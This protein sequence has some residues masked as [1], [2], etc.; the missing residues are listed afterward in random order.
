MTIKIINYN[1][2]MTIQYIISKALEDY[3][4]YKPV[5]DKLTKKNNRV[6]V[7]NSKE[8]TKRDIIK[9]FD[10]NNKLLVES[11]YEILG[12]Y[13]PTTNIWTWGWAAPELKHP[14]N[15]LSHEI[16]NH[17]MS[18]DNEKL[19]IKSMLIN[20]RS[21]ITDEIQIDINLAICTSIIKHY[22]IYPLVKTNETSSVVIYLILLNN[23]QLVRMLKE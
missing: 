15:F 7:I 18:W 1:Q 11:E 9:I 10:K 21:S 16:F 17:V 12:L 22:V 6:E 5:S 23:H 3:D 4:A 20:S 14:H 19:Y 8:D 13:Y 2:K